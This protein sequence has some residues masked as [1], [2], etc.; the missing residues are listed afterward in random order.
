MDR[1][2]AIVVLKLLKTAYPRF[3]ADIT[4]EDAENMV[5]LWI[6]M[7]KQDDPS[8]VILAVKELINTLKFPPAI[9][10]VKEKMYAITTKTES[11]AELWGALAKAVR[12]GLYGYREEFEKLPDVVKTFV[13]EPAQLREMAQMDSD[14]FHTVTKGQFLKQIEVIQKRQKEDKMMLP[15]VKNLMLQ[16]TSNWD[17]QKLLN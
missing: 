2:Q 8:L 16:L 5:N 7:F 10:D 9:A 6:D 12:N 11:P 17:S 4:K 3:Y 1:E 15:E 13:R 14:T